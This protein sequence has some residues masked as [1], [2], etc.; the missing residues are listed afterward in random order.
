MQANLDN[1]YII[2]EKKTSKKMCQLLYCKS[3]HCSVTRYLLLHETRS[4]KGWSYIHSKFTTY[5]CKTFLYRNILCVNAILCRYIMRRNPWLK[6]SILWLIE[7]VVCIGSNTFVTI[8]ERICTHSMA[9]RV[10]EFSSRGYKIR[11]IFV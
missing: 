4:Y 3:G 1:Y 9:I 5:I 8:C 10:V 6:W 2:V 7:R 11:K